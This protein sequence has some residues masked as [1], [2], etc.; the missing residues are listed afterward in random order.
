MPHHRLL[1]KMSKEDLILAVQSYGCG[2]LK[3]LPLEYMTKEQ[4]V[5]HLKN[6]SCELIKRLVQGKI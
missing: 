4:L 2:M 6:C 3:T 1:D 5:D